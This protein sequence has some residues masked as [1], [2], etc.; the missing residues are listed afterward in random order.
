MCEAWIRLGDVNVYLANRETPVLRGI[1]LELRAGEWLAV[2][3]RNGCG[4]SVLG[5]LL[6]GLEGCYSGQLERSHEGEPAQ[7]R[8]IMQ[9]PEAQLIGETVWDDICFGLEA[10]CL[11][12]EE[13]HEA[14]SEALAAV[15]LKGME[16]QQV[17]RL[18]GGQKQLVALAGAIA[19]KPA[20]LVADEVTSMLDP[21][22]RA[23]VL[24]VLRSMNRQGLAVIMITQLLEEVIHADR[25]IALNQEGTIAYEG[26]AGPFFY[27]SGDSHSSRCE[28]LGLLPPYTVR[29]AQEFIRRGI[30]LQGFP[31][32]PEE[33]EQAVPVLWS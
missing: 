3:G 10:L 28:A 13:I 16:E 15:G 32:T 22:S 31:I 6:A 18:S 33:L 25:M 21:A 1:N 4:K 2:V 14:A 27:S 29:V 30:P 26:L 23:K 7:I 12:P 5:K 20:I 9:N 24:Q 8:W 11:S 17:H 19:M